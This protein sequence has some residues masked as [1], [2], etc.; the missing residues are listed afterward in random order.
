M[1]TWWHTH[2]KSMCAKISPVIAWD[3]VAALWSIWYTHTHESLSFWL[4][5]CLPNLSPCSDQ[6]S[7]LKMLR[8]SLWEFLFPKSPQKCRKKS[9]YL[10]HSKYLLGSP[11]KVRQFEQ[12][13]HQLLTLP[14]NTNL[15]HHWNKVS[16]HE[17]QGIACV[18]PKLRLRISS[19][20][21]L[22]NFWSSAKTNCF[23]L[24]CGQ[25]I[26]QV[27][28]PCSRSYPGQWNWVHSSFVHVP[29]FQGSKIVL[30]KI[31]NL[32]QVSLDFSQ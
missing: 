31:W 3:F 20:G 12:S 29:N 14:S 24:E 16:N 13:D 5:P 28:S 1:V 18:V 32:F 21:V 22:S 17:I 26:S 8:I 9:F 11:L 2:S 7:Q 4:S 6:N 30:S 23:V 27:C 10:D 19:Q 15:L 25:D